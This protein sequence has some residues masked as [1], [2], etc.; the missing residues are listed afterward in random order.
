MVAFELW[1]QGRHVTTFAL[2]IT[3]IIVGLNQIDWG[4]NNK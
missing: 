1:H 3:A 4:I 2:G